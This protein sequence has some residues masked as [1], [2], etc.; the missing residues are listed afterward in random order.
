MV[1][2]EGIIIVL[3]SIGLAMRFRVS[4]MGAGEWL[5]LSFFVSLLIFDTQSNVNL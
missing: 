3:L 5:S 1:A 2:E 4:K